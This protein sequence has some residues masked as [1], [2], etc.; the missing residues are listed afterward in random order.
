MDARRFTSKTD[1]SSGL[2][3][4]ERQATQRAMAKKNKKTAIELM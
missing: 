4:V 3:P 1:Q 2:W